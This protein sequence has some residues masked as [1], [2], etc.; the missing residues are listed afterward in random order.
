MQS[1]YYNPTIGRFLNADSLVST[2]QGLLGNNMFAYCGNNPIS[3]ADDGGEFW[4]IVIGAVAGAI[5][6]AV[7]EL[8]SQVINHV[9]TGEDIDWGDVATSAAGG[10]VYGGVMAATGSKMAA[11]IASTATTSVINGVR[12]GD[13]VGKIITD[14]AKNTLI[15]AATCA[16]PKVINKSLSGKYTKLN[17]VQKFVKKATSGPY[18]GKYS[19]GPNYLAYSFSYS[20]KRARNNI[21]ITIGKVTAEYVGQLIFS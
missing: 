14:T 15:T 2:G 21:L 18:Q 6:S 13:S 4:N 19:S 7:S 8:V 11:S 20:T 12:S 17:S 1:R 3:R 16:A 9:A 5:A 10:A